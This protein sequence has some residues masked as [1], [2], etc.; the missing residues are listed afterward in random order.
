MQM[1]TRLFRFLFVKCAQR[2]ALFWKITFSLVNNI[3]KLKRHKYIWPVCRCRK[4][5]QNRFLI[6][7]KRFGENGFFLYAT[8]GFIVWLHADR[9]DATRRSMNSNRGNWAEYALSVWQTSENYH[10]CVHI[11]KANGNNEKA[12]NGQRKQHTNTHTIRLQ[13]SN[14]NNIRRELCHPKCLNIVH[15][16]YCTYCINTLL[17]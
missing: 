7:A 15:G 11:N 3:H 9:S 16:L 8:N 14:S 10:R 13:A 6:V 12:N 5:Q 2:V 4:I 17:V 1:L